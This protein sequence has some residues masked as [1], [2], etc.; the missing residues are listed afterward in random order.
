MVSS[1]ECDSLHWGDSMAHDSKTQE[2][3][4]QIWA[5]EAGQNCPGTLAILAR[6]HD[7]TSVPLRTLQ[8]WASRGWVERV[9]RDL[10]AIAP[11]IR[12]KTISEIVLGSLEAAQGLRRVVRGDEAPDRTKVMAYLGMLDR[13]G[14]SHIGNAPERRIE[15]PSTQLTGVNLDTL[16]TDELLALQASIIE[17]SRTT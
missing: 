5:F 8:D 7:V 1:G 3:A 4:Y 2:L 9:D 12:K 10:S 16:S 15:S 6:D 11:A 17:D 14:F 13:G